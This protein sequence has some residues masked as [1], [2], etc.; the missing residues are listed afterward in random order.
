MKTIPAP[1][2]TA[3]ELLKPAQCAK[4]IS[5]SR[6]TLTNLV[7]RRIIPSI[8]IGKIRLFSLEKVKAALEKFEEIEVTR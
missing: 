1:Q 4:A 8:S 7:K 3:P 6:R 2:T 5:V